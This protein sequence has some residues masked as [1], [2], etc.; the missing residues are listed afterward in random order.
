M[1]ISDSKLR[2]TTEPQINKAKSNLDLAQNSLMQIIIPD[3]FS[4]SSEL[5]KIQG[6]IEQIKKDVGD[7]NSYIE[8]KIDE[9]NNADKKSMKLANSLLKGLSGITGA[10]GKTI[11]GTPAQNANANPSSS[12][13]P[14][15][16]LNNPDYEYYLQTQAGN[17]TKNY[18]SIYPYMV[19]EDYIQKDFLN[20]MSNIDIKKYKDFGCVSLNDYY[21]MEEYSKT[22][23]YGIDQG[24]LDNFIDEH[25]IYYDTTVGN[26]VRYV[27]NTDNMDEKELQEHIR[28]LEANGQKVSI[29]RNNN[30]VKYPSK[31]DTID[32]VHD[33]YNMNYV[34]AAETISMVD[35]IGACSYA[36]LA[37]CLEMQYRDNPEV[38][39]KATGVPLYKTDKSGNK[40]IN[41]TEIML[42]LYIKMNL[43]DVTNVPERPLFKKNDKGRIEVIEYEEDDDY[44]GIKQAYVQSSSGHDEQLIKEYFK[45]NGINAQVLT[46]HYEPKSAS[47]L[48]DAIISLKKDIKDGYKVSLGVYAKKDFDDSDDCICLY[49]I[50][51]KNLK[52]FDK[53][54]QETYYTFTEGGHVMTITGITKDGV[55]V[56]SWGKRMYVSFEELNNNKNG[57]YELDSIKVVISNK[58]KD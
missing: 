54:N 1:Y 18:S 46:K 9:Y 58:T 31:F 57:K 44:D 50:S 22:G 32:Y 13:L 52:S 16:M 5:S 3:N 24:V 20:T 51:N 36:D 19:N 7:I 47:E 41:S 8:A 12:W 6:R 15:N 11:F 10:L 27:M 25:I 35:A 30:P 39:E 53:E 56:D 29:V 38:F 55:I 33:K 43:G 17:V 14:K 45:Y 34:D 26:R 4:Y 42:D 48:K 21:Y 28:M 2:Q 37:N 23:N 40:Y 49:D